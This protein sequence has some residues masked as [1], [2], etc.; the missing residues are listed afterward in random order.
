MKKIFNFGSRRELSPG[1]SSFSPHP[2]R[3]SGVRPFGPQAGYVVK[4]KELGKIH[5]AAAIGDVAKVQQ[6]LL[7]GLASVDDLDK[8]NRTPLHLACAHGFPDVVSLLVER[9]CKLNLRDSDSLTPLIKSVQCQQEECAVILLE[10]GADSTLVDTNNN[11]ALHYAA[12]GLNIAIAA[13]LLRHKMDIEAKNKEGYT[14]LLLAITENN[15]DMVEFFLKN[16]ANVNASD[17]FQRTALMIALSDEPTGIVSLLLQYDVD[18]SCKD[19]YGWTAEEYAIVSGHSIHYQLINQYGRQKALNQPLPPKISSSER[20]SD[21]ESTLRVPAMNQE[22]LTQA[23]E[24]KESSEESQESFNESNPEQNNVTLEATNIPVQIAPKKQEKPLNFPLSLKRMSQRLEPN[25]ESHSSDVY[26][27]EDSN[28][29][30]RYE[31][32]WVAKEKMEVKKNFKIITTELKQMFGEISEKNKIVAQPPEK[33]HEEEPQDGFEKESEQLQEASP[34]IANN[35]SDTEAVEKY[36]GP[37]N[38]GVQPF[39]EQR[40]YSLEN[41]VLQNL[42]L[43]FQENVL[44]SSSNLCSESSSLQHENDNN[45]EIECICN[46]NEED[47]AYDAENTKIANSQI[48][49]NEMKEDGA[50]GMQLAGSLN[51]NTPNLRAGSGHLLQV[52]GVGSHF[53]VWHTCSDDMKSITQEKK[54]KLT[55]ATKL[56][57][58]T[59]LKENL[60]H[61]SEHNASKSPNKLRHSL[62]CSDKM[63]KTHLDKDLNQDMHIFEN[64]LGV[65]QVEFL[66]FEEKKIQLQKEIE[67]EQKKHQHNEI[68]TLEGKDDDKLI[69][70]R[71]IGNINELFSVESNQHSKDEENNIPG[72]EIPVVRIS[73]FKESSATVHHHFKGFFYSETV[74]SASLEGEGGSDSVMQ[75]K[76]VKTSPKDKWISEDPG[77]N[78]SCEKVNASID[79]LLRGPEDSSLSEADHDE[80]RP[81]K[82]VLNEKNKDKVETDADDVD[83]L[84]QSSDTAT[85][86]YALPPLNHKTVSLLIEQLSVKC[87]DTISLLK[88]QD[89]VL[90]YERS[91]E[92]KKGHCTR[93][94]RK[95]KGLENKITG[96]QE[97]LLETREMKSQL[98]HQKAESDR[99]LSILRFTLK[100]EEKKRVTAEVLFEKIRER[101]RRKEEEY[102][103]EVNLKQQLEFTQRA[104]D[105]ELRRVRNHLKQVEE[106]RNDTQRQLSQ[107]LRARALQSG[108]HNNPLWKQKEIEAC[109]SKM[110][111]T[112]E[113]PDSNEKEKYLLDKN[114]ILQDEVAMLQVELDTLKIKD[115]EKASQFTEENEVLKEENDELQKKLQLNEEALT[116]I[117]SQYSGQVN[118]LTSENAMLN[119]ELENAKQ[120]RARLETET[121]SYR[122]RLTSAVRD[123]ERSQ[124]S[125]LDLERTFQRERDEWLHLQRK[126]NHDLSSLRENNADLCQKLSK[127]ENKA[128]SLGNELYHVHDSLREKVLFL[129]STQRQLNQAQHK[130][131]ELEHTNQLEKEKLK[132][133]VAK[134]ESIQERFAQI[135]GENMLLQQQL[136]DAQN[137]GIIK[138]KVLSDAQ[139]EF[140]DLFNKLRADTEKQVLMVEERNKELISECERL[141]EQMCKYENEKAEREATLRNLQQELADL[142]KTQSMTKAS[143]ED[144]SLFRNDLEDKKKLQ[145]ELHQTKSKLNNEREKL[146]K[147]IELKQSVENR[148][149]RE[150][151]KNEE[152]QKDLSGFKKLLKTTKKKLREYEKGDVVYQE[153]VKQ[154]YSTIEREI[155]VLKNRI[156]DL[157]QQLEA[158][159][160]KCKKLESINQ[161]LQE[162]LLSVKILQ[163]K[164]DTLEGNKRKLEGEVVNLKHHLEISKLQCSEIELYKSEIDEHARQ[165]IMK[166]LKEVNLF[167]QTQAIE[168]DNL[169]Q[170]R[171]N[172]NA[173]VRNQMEQR[174]RDLESKLY[175]MKNSHQDSTE[176]EIEKYRQLYSEELKL[177][178]S[179]SD[180]L[181]R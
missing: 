140:I 47:V 62:P 172:S 117:I 87:K 146:K 121:E 23:L 114:Q 110:T 115:Q 136:E 141:R 49:V 1:R 106:E 18:L 38:V 113:V 151:K 29:E 130:A 103:I 162:E 178:K 17:R 124:T 132:K 63:P 119:S 167:L 126:L 41:A 93:L 44:Q 14:P 64:E 107:E 75:K 127:A 74:T 92:L 89:A 70:N 43:T 175:E 36:G 52:S 28:W 125:K 111:Q 48:A 150:T 39:P 176:A 122:S 108:I 45:P 131:K 59:K 54:P 35:S 73:S 13:K 98:E 139:G 46:L 9:K 173:L 99:E 158:Q 81:A 104:L 164:C 26:L 134:H 76:E 145:K 181:D 68:E 5:K 120:N 40:E 128:S 170:L 42:K 165:Q 133:Y 67:E 156:E 179:L 55:A 105:V 56:N 53:G 143:L 12:S 171:E 153:G 159:F 88:I 27:H 163:K 95:V 82:K 31:K 6:L 77:I 152:L 169:E 33:L 138:E 144:T 16:G 69:E 10:H 20:A 57:K 3:D 118:V 97:E 85:E 157:T 148:L 123:H 66:A 72:E 135:Q 11:T 180:K 79:V 149:E 60:F 91:V 30:E 101:L 51:R 166:K 109:A 34:N 83:D 102:S 22:D 168:Q 4:M 8:E 129:E 174:I 155:N 37:L 94:A 116:K 161:S 154:T 24:F 2:R 137:K 25:K 112:S 7:L 96:L 15:Q 19:T 147:L 80:E 32:M 71:I 58:I 65:L 21:P 61:S 142:K 100:Q 90:R 84:T 177:R 50:V 160:S 78:S 86:D